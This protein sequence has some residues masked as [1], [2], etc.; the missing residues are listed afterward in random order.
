MHELGQL[1]E[2]TLQFMLINMRNWL[3]FTEH[4]T[5]PPASYGIIGINE[6]N[7]YRL[8]LDKAYKRIF[9]LANR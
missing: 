4:A 2:D 1:M 9:A 8:Q 5:M 3:N 6:S 7:G